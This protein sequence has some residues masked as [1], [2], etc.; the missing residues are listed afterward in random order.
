MYIPRL[1]CFKMFEHI[2]MD[3]NR[4]RDEKMERFVKIIKPLPFLWE[5]LHPLLNRKS[6]PA[7]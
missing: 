4:I 1:I 7:F 3:D 2:K 5:L 6:K